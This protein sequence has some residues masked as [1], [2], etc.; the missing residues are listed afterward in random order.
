MLG[1]THDLGAYIEDTGEVRVKLANFAE[2][3]KAANEMEEFIASFTPDPNFMYLHVIA[4][5]SGEYYGCNKN[6]DYFPEKALIMYHHTFVQNAKVFKEHNNKSDSPDYGKVAKSW[7]NK[8]MHRVELLLAVD[9]KKA[10]DI[11]AAVN[12]GEHLE[13]SMGARV[14]YDVCSI[15]GNKA[16]KKSEYCEHIRYNN[17]RVYPDGKQAFMYNLQP[18]FFDISFVKRR[19]DKIAMALRK[20]A[21]DVGNIDHVYDVDIVDKVATITKIAPAEAVLKVLNAGMYNK[22]EKLEEM[23][24]DLPPA[25]LDRMALRYSLPDI[26]TTFL[27][28]FIPMKPHEV[29]RI[30]VVQNGL[31][32][33]SYE[34]VLGGVLSAKRDQPI[35]KGE[36]QYEIENLLER[37]LPH[38]SS[39]GPH[40]VKRVLGLREKTAN[41][42]DIFEIPYKDAPY[43]DPAFA[44]ELNHYKHRYSSVPVMYSPEE[45]QKRRYELEHRPP[46]RKPM[47]PFALGLMLGSMYASYRGVSGLKSVVDTLTSTKGLATAGAVSLAAVGAMRG[48]DKTAGV[49]DSKLTT[50]FVLPFVGAHLASAHYRNKYM[51]GEELNS[52]QKFVAEN[53]DYLSVAAPFA[54]HF[55]AKKFNSVVNKVAA[56]CNEQNKLANFA[57]TLSQAA[58]TGIIFRGRGMSGVGNVADQAVDAVLMQQAVKHTTP[59]QESPPVAG[60]IATQLPEQQKVLKPATQN[61]Y[62]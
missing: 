50:H 58:L 45:Y 30:I 16:A 10:P 42:G 31:P 56:E 20:V 47:N 57:D 14:P 43:Y 27:H 53:P 37:F 49:M 28:N 3:S 18:T 13:V 19:A 52:V 21:S 1:K 32:M 55:G 4:M 7:Y 8:T 51:R 61:M 11:V 17:K 33:E 29:S 22:L 12:R 25:M 39:L 44:N 40:V 60:V 38:R 5:G 23:E 62:I 36:Y 24:P 54:I 35:E 2:L 6:G 41:E 46:L 48:R 59:Q 26:L 15:C 34:E 9:K